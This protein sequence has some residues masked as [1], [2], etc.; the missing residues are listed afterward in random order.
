MAGPFFP[1]RTYVKLFAKEISRECKIIAKAR[2]VIVGAVA[3]ASPSN[4]AAI[5]AALDALQG[6]CDVWLQVAKDIDA[7]N[8]THEP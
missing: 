2:P 5:N 7:Y 4:L 1:V 6:M 3:L 8:A